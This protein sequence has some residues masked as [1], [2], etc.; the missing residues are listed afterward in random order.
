MAL[1]LPSST[2]VSGKT[3][4]TWNE[5]LAT[6][7]KKLFAPFS[8]F[9]VGLDIETKKVTTKKNDNFCLN[10]HGGKAHAT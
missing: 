2:N 3:P 8:I 1:S 9:F 10:V 6:L 5:I 4:E 7:L